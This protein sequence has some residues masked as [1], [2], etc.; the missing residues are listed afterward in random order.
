LWN[1]LNADVFASE[2]CH[3][4]DTSGDCESVAQK[5]AEAP[6]KRKKKKKNT[7]MEKVSKS[8]ET[9]KTATLHFVH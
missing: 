7:A 2:E 9:K 8:T 6:L 1:G 4:L 5:G 3:S